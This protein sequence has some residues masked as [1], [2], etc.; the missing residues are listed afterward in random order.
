[1]DCSWKENWEETKRCFVRWWKREGLVLGMW[2]GPPAPVPREDLP[3]PGN[4]LSPEDGYTDAGNRALRNHYTLAQQD[5]PADILPICDANIG[6]GSL[7]LYL[8]SEPT[9][10]NDTVWFHPSR[11]EGDPEKTGPISFRPGNPCR[12]GASSSVGSS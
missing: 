4:P 9:F 12:R 2:G 7:A 8:G 3:F 6:P 11:A 1:M 10:T 5:F